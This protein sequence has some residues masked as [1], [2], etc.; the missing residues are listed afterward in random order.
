M[1]YRQL[2]LILS[3]HA[4]ALL[5]LAGAALAQVPPVSD[6]TSQAKSV[7]ES[8]QFYR[9]LHAVLSH[10]RCVNCHPKDDTPKQ[11]LDGHIH[12]PP[13]TRG[14][15]DSGPPGLPCM[16]C[17]N[18][19]NFDPAHMP[20]AP[21]WHMAPASM[22][23]EGKSPGELCRALTDRSKNGRR[24]LPATVKHLTQD[25]LVAWGWEPGIYIGGKPR[26]PVPMPKAEFDRI[27]VAWANS[28]GT[29][30]D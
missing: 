9:Q 19:A 24:D 7:T 30:P 16:T 17:H 2:A 15:G 18:E 20:G 13:I 23:W 11:G 27:V 8:I 14:P 12:T 4:L 22:A 25:K 10:P 6:A 29:C 26:E 5:G 28:G 3:A 1:I 21:S